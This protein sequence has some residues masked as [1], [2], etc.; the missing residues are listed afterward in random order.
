V[1]NCLN[2][3][4]LFAEGAFKSHFSWHILSRGNAFDVF[5]PEYMKEAVRR[6]QIPAA[7]E[8]AKNF[9]PVNFGWI[10]DESPVENSIGL[11]PDMVEYICSRGAAWNCPVSLKGDLGRFPTYPRGQDNMEVFRRWEEF[12]NNGIITKKEKEALKN[13]D[14]EHFL[15][16]NR[17]GEFELLPY[18]QI[19]DVAGGNPAIRA[20]HYSRKGKNGVI[21]WH[22]IANGKL[23]VEAK[24]HFRLYED[25]EQDI[26]VDI[27]GEKVILPVGKR[28][29]F[30]TNRPVEELI[31]LF[32]NAKV[33]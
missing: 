7:R 26:P 4:P 22:T 19:T 25:S 5:K 3:A 33:I 23:E 28:R 29:Y 1:Y 16:L 18:A 31:N 9:T 32:K 20:F 6:H 27:K 14:Q 13:P 24:G 11:Q 8:M 17:K 12:R 15:F 30:E 2:P 10:R 21:Y